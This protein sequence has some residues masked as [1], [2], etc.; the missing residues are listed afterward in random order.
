MRRSNL[1][2]AAAALLLA[3]PMQA[4]AY[5]TAWDAIQALG[6]PANDIVDVTMSL[7]SENM[8]GT[9]SSQGVISATYPPMGLLYTGIYANMTS[10]NDD[11]MP[12]MGPEA[13]DIIEIRVTLQTP[14]SMHSFKFNFYFLSREYPDYVGS[15]FND[16]FTV[17]QS[18]SIFNGNIVFDQGGNVIDVNSALFTVTNQALLTGTGFDCG[19]RGG[20]TGWL[21][22]ISPAVPNE[23]FTLR[24]LIGDVSDGIYDSAVFLDAF[25]WREEEEKEP[26]PAQPIGLRFLSPKVG[27]T[28]GGQ[29]T[30][31]YGNDFTADCNVSFDGVEVH[32]TTMLSSER[33]Q[34]VTP[35][36]AVGMVNVRVW[37]DS[38]DDTLTNG[39]TFSD[40]DPSTMP[41]ELAEADPPIGPL[42]GGI[43]VDVWGG[44]FGESTGIYFDGVEAD[45]TLKDSATRFD[46]DL[47]AYGGGE[48]E[49]VVLIEAINASGTEASPPL[50][51]TYSENAPVDGPGGQ[52]KGCN[53]DVR[54]SGPG[55][56]AGLASILLV[57]LGI[58]RWRK[59]G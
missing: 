41:P 3:M 16:T 49:A 52:G 22:T 21:T 46:C 56:A 11:D 19:Y 43:D 33:L 18:S 23:Q 32:D 57:I 10:C 7:G 39:Y 30:V 36:H 51:F 27:P 31:I 20:G 5:A 34:V 45:C 35:P 55:R 14:P 13:G 29:T 1:V 37:S 50:T 42:E 59:E 12:P 2:A 25:E 47:P 53:C 28:E 48:P 38:S 4:R 9:M 15:Q 17:M 26:H 24:F 44:N 40:E 6:I 58:R 54:G 8:M